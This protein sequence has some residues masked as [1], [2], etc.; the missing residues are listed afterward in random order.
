MYDSAHI[1]MAHHFLNSRCLFFC[2]F[3]I[4]SLFIYSFGGSTAGRYQSIGVQAADRLQQG[5]SCGNTRIRHYVT[6]RYKISSQIYVTPFKF[7]LELL[8]V[9]LITLILQLSSSVITIYRFRLDVSV[10]AVSVVS[11][12]SAF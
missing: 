2:G 11:A 6:L 9:N 4:H 7:S 1:N 3:F 8:P 12:V 5:L 10:S